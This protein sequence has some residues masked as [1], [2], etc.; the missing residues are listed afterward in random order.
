[1]T[2]DEAIAL[3][4]G[5]V[6]ADG[7]TWADLGAGSGTFT[8]ALASLLGERGI[9]HAVDRDASSLRELDSYAR[10]GRPRAAAIHTRVGD[11][12]TDLGLRD[13]DGVVIA[14]AL[15]FVPYDGQ[16]AALATV[17]RMMKTGGTIVV[18]EYDRRGPNRWVPYPVSLELLGTI[19]LEAGLS[20][21]RLLT[22][23]PSR[24][25]GTIYSASLGV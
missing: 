18:V 10:R 21:P 9:V 7:G 11:L 1:V 14:N 15:H 4:S 22:T 8:R 23:R 12:T 3:I 6:T 20:E 24:Y 13:M 2:Q 5:A 17:R 16:A 19:A 25:S